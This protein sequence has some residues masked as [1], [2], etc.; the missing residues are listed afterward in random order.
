MRIK[1]TEI[2]TLLATVVVVVMALP[3]Q[4]TT[5]DDLKSAGFVRG[6]TAN[7]VP[8]GYMDASG[9]AKGIGPDVAAAVLRNLV[10]RKLIGQ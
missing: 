2:S 9:A 8:Y 6:A 1:L 3:S 7:E 4:A 10:L 5:I